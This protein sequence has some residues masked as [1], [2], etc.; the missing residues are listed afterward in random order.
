MGPDVSPPHAESDRARRSGV[1]YHL[2]AIAVV[3]SV[4]ALIGLLQDEDA[5]VEDEDQD[6]E[7]S[8]ELKATSARIL[9]DR[10]RAS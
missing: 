4:R 2:A 8:R 3:R 9:Y 1:H 7:M 10:S 6:A 5:I